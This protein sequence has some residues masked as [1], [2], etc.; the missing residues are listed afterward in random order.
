MLQ[1]DTDYLSLCA[2]QLSSP[3]SYSYE[4][5]PRNMSVSRSLSLRNRGFQSDKFSLMSTRY[6]PY[7]NTMSLK[8]RLRLHCIPM[9]RVRY[10]QTL[11]PV[12]SEI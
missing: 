3:H 9:G 11:K 4:S 6:C 5:M 12:K 8:K 10:G 1:Q 2:L 7:L